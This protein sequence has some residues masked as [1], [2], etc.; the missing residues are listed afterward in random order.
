MT[1]EMTQTGRLPLLVER[2][3]VERLDGIVGR[4]EIPALC[5]GITLIYGPNAS[6]KSRTATALQGL[7]WP[8]T[9][10][11][12]AEF[13]GSLALAGDQWYVT[14]MDRRGEYLRNGVRIPAPDLVGIPSAQRD[15]YVLSLHDLL[16]ADS[17]AFAEV[18]QQETMGGFNLAKAREACGLGKTAPKVAPGKLAKDHQRT[19]EVI[20]TLRGQDQALRGDE[21]RIASLARQR[22]AAV[23]AAETARLL[24]A[25]LDYIDAQDALC[26]AEIM[27][28]RFPAQLS[29][30]SGSEAAQI[31]KITQAI[32][33][34]N[35]ERR[36][37]NSALDK[38]RHDLERSGFASGLPPAEVLPQ[39]RGRRDQLMSLCSDLESEMR[40]IT[41]QRAQCDQAQR[42]LGD[43]ID[44]TKMRSFDE[45]GLRA[46]A[47]LKRTYEEAQNEVDARNAMERWIGSIQQPA[48]LAALRR[49]VELLSDWLREPRGDTSRGPRSM[50]KIALLL[51]AGLI[52]IQALILGSRISPLFFVLAVL[53]APVA[54]VAF[55][56]ERSMTTGSSQQREQ[57]YSGLMLEPI[58]EWTPASVIAVLGQLRRRLTDA[59]IENQ[60]H[61]LWADMA[62]RRRASDELV[63]QKFSEMQ[64]VIDEFGITIDEDPDTL[65]QAADALEKWRRCADDLATA[66]ATADNIHARISQGLNE[67][68]A[69]LTGL[70]ANAAPNSADAG[71]T[72]DEL[73]RRITRARN[74]TDE[75]TRCRQD[76]T[77]RIDPAITAG[78]ADLDQIYLSLG[79]EPGDSRTVRDW[80]A[81]FGDYQ[82]A[83][84]AVDKAATVVVTRRQALESAPELV[85]LTRTEIDTRLAAA[86]ELAGQ[87]DE[88]LK[89]ISEI[90][91]SIEAAKRGSN[92]E[93]AIAR[94]IEARDLL[95]AARSCDDAQAAAWRVAE[96]VHQ[97]THAVNRPRVFQVAADYFAR[98]TAGAF[99]LDIEDSSSPA[100]FAIDTS[101]QRPRALNE[102]SSGTRIQ[103]L[104]A[105]RLAFIETMEH[106]PR[107]P[108]LLDEVL[109][110]TD[111]LRAAAIIDA[112]IEICRSGRQVIYFTAQ[113]DE[114]AKWKSRASL[115]GDDVKISVVDLADIR[116]L[117]AAEVTFGIDWSP[118]LSASTPVPDG[119]DHAAARLLFR[120]PSIDP[121]AGSL[122]S[123]DLWYLIPDVTALA[124]LRELSIT[125]WGQYL[126]MRPRGIG[127]IVA[128]F[129]QVDARAEHLARALEAALDTWRIGRTPPLTRTDLEASL[130]ISS[131]FMEPVCALADRCGWDGAAILNALRDKE[132]SGFHQK[133]ITGLEDYLR[134]NGFVTTATPEPMVKIR[135][136]ALAAA[137]GGIEQAILGIHDIDA[138]LERA[139]GG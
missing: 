58:A 52:V 11:P 77:N 81:K 3:A 96:F 99:Q 115:D 56:I 55:K 117:A 107:L 25:A 1:P 91:A 19:R 120:V 139:A 16:V 49:A 50:D 37:K 95:L 27:R 128:G 15:R 66:E 13:T 38:A 137:A 30:M 41:Q 45:R 127:G 33:I 103:L 92:L 54:G 98:F 110:N 119:T 105:V 26:E 135:T 72:I 39:L 61:T 87:A 97:Q 22:G 53:A 42:R 62:D 129:E 125:T 75:I 8:D 29:Q 69:I 114:I 57:E 111:D 123:V 80:C 24:R 126:E 102:L 73:E 4:F 108:L 48:N 18:V 63:Q 40:T 64:R 44:G 79:L 35:E 7:I 28:D 134:L 133:S 5:P 67:L 68:N 43:H 116:K 74:A 90:K 132:I 124:G 65:D 89:Q 86:S 118:S 104:M 85:E 9:T 17:N 60:K 31:D 71:A 100:F 136:M 36:E 47:S 21:T 113:Q 32:T 12:R 51:A 84:K 112:T 93:S 121:W 88:F 122:A 83:V 106:G 23:A 20:R 2:V 76:L 6:G 109:G 82:S 78:Q 94:E 70:G 59:E 131:V 130:A 46:L 10:P 138:L 34:L 101:T 14:S